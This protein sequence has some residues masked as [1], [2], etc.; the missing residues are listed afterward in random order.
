MT[1]L[2]PL[3]APLEVEDATEEDELARDALLEREASR[4]AAPKASASSDATVLGLNSPP[5]WL[6][7]PQEVPISD[8]AV[9]DEFVPTGPDGGPA[10]AGGPVFRVVGVE[11]GYVH[12]KVVKQGQKYTA[13]GF[14]K[15]GKVLRFS[16]NY[17]VLKH[18]GPLWLPGE[19]VKVTKPGDKNGKTGVVIGHA[20]DEYTV[21]TSGGQ[22]LEVPGGCLSTER[23]ARVQDG[24]LSPKV[25]A[26]PVGALVV[27]NFATRALEVVG[28]DPTE[29]DTDGSPMV[30]VKASGADPAA[31]EREGSATG[32]VGL[33]LSPATTVAAFWH[34]GRVT[35]EDVPIRESEALDL[36]APVERDLVASLA[37]GI[38]GVIDSGNMK[39]PGQ[40]VTPGELSPLD[41]FQ[42]SSGAVYVVKRSELSGS[43][44]WLSLETSTGDEI[45]VSYPAHADLGWTITAVPAA[46]GR[47]RADVPQEDE[48][49]AATLVEAL[50]AEDER[51]E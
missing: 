15:P 21:K 17:A 36:V 28:P 18:D 38:R 34:A 24:G 3:L 7:N 4:A 50:V 19:H 26:V 5:Q 27:T 39:I 10:A 1:A 47:A 6:K 33:L 32:D 12:A 8:L 31:F 40:S 14:S 13:Y 25:D 23:A 16:E 9:G 43:Q 48:A 44:A 49:E 22:N 20:G 30:R 35:V 29:Q 46:P 45:T 41:Y 2:D 11:P 42:S 37:R 51:T